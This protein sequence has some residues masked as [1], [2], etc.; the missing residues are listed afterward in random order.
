MAKASTL[1]LSPL[2]NPRRLELRQTEF[3]DA[4]SRRADRDDILEVAHDLTK[5][6]RLDVG[7]MRESIRLF[8]DPSM[9]ECLH[10]HDREFPLHPEIKIPE[11]V[12]PD[13]EFGALVRRRRSVREFTGESLGRSALSTLL[14][15]AVGETGRTVIGSAGSRPVS[16]SLR[17]IPSG[18]ALH[19]TEMFVAIVKKD[20]LLPGIYHYHVPAHTLEQVKPMGE[21]EL[22]QLF[23]ALPIHPQIVNLTEASAIFFICSKFWRARAKYGPRG[24]RWCLVEA[25]AACQN[26]GLTAVA[27]GLGHVVLGGFYDEEIHAW[28]EID[29]IEEAVIVAVAVGGLRGKEEL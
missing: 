14:F 16:V 23:G 1:L 11:P 12:I 25:G 22:D 8:E 2:E 19:P 9:Q 3:L 27:L 13:C 26:L 18:G 6:R 29:G 10:S 28:L 20:E 15:G 21:S 5:L 17:S 7:G 24:Y 4:Y